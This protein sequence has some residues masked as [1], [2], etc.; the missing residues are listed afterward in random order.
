MLPDL[1]AVLRQLT[2]MLCV[3]GLFVAT[4]EC[5]WNRASASEKADAKTPDLPALLEATTV[6]ALDGATQ[7]LLYWAPESAT[8]AA[9]PMLVFLHSWSGD[10]RQDNSKWLK[11]AVDRNW[12]FLHPNF[13][14]RNDHLTACGSKYA[15]QDIL[16]AMALMRSTLQVD[17]ERIYLA[18][19]S[20]GGH[21]SMLM[22]GHH[23]DQ[24]SAVSAWVGISD[25]TEWHTFHSKKNMPDGYDKM[26]V[27]SL[28]GPPGFSVE[29]D[30]QYRERSPLFHL[31]QTGDLPLD[32][33]AGVQDGHTGSVPVSHSLKAFNVIAETRGAARVTEQEMT[34]LARD[35]RL[36]NPLASDQEADAVL[37][38]G[39]FLR[40]AAGNS[41]VTIF[42]GGHEG[43]PTPACEWLA[44]QKRRVSP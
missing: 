9:T 44:Q 5:V 14:G 8:T 13:R 27:A 12:I 20:G 17:P 23:P 42:A 19:T 3:A 11:E 15:R 32:I 30:Q 43:L 16:D 21:M 33:A 40:R 25:L 39:I 6:S 22:A 26:I 7:P 10:Y 35:Q 29:V 34:E 18:G 24:F 31:H 1:P 37:A 36:A 2:R 28:G 41:R 38:R 4:S